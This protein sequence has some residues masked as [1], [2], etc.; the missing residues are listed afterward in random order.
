MKLLSRSKDEKKIS[1]YIICININEMVRHKAIIREFIFTRIGICV[2]DKYESTFD[3]IFDQAT[4]VTVDLWIKIFHSHIY[5]DPNVSQLIS[6][7]YAKMI[8]SGK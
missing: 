2:T 4:R 8:P 6:H 7:H 3:Q 1:I 5:D